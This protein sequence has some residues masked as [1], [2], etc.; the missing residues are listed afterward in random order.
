NP[1]QAVKKEAFEQTTNIAEMENKKQ[2]LAKFHEII[3]EST[4]IE[5]GVPVR[6]H[7]T[8]NTEEHV[9]PGLFKKLT[10]GKRDEMKE[11]KIILL[12]GQTGTG[13][14]KIINS[15]V[16]FVLGVTIED[17]VWFEITDDQCD[18]TQAHSQTSDIT[19][20]EFFLHQS[21]MHLTIIDTPG[22]GDRCVGNAKKIADGLFK[23]SSYDWIKQLDAVCL[24]IKSTET[25]LSKEYI[26]IF[27]AIQSLFGKNIFENIVLFFTFS[28]GA[29]PKN[30]LTAVNDAQIK[31]A[32]N[33]ENEPL[34]FLFDNCQGETFHTEFIEVQQQSWRISL[35]GMNGFFQFLNSTE[36]KPLKMT[37]DV[38]DQRVKLEEEIHRIKERNQQINEKQK[39]LNNIEEQLETRKNFETE[40][41]VI[42]KDLVDID[43]SLASI[44]VRCTECKENCHYPG[45]WW[46][47]PLSWSVVIKNN[48]CK[49]CFKKCHISKHIKDAKIYVTKIRKE[50][51]VDPDLKQGYE[52]LQA[53][54]KAREEEVQRL[55]VDKMKR[56]MDAF[57]SINALEMIA[58]NTDSLMTLFHIDFLI[59]ELKNIN[60]PEKAKI[61]EHIKKRAGA[62]KLKALENNV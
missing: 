7:I 49:M 34:Y 50:K 32:V 51:R 37:R 53:Q 3:N 43:R 30:A 40:V 60:E 18:R 38:I 48:K 17:S 62:D 31:C 6:Y 16:N 27:D 14:T 41:D 4:K 15:M 12:L 44:A 58:L 61:L 19:L 1:G 13:K 36:A 25:R 24:V 35:K 54:R 23:L 9:E 26:R 11:H 29:L 45:S 46:I 21:S 33:E 52:D 2:G 8:P 22:Y 59:E 5:D 47:T 39:E 56:V 20:Y 55:K 42:Y 10:F 28:R 57:H